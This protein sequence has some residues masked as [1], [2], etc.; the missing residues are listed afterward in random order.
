MSID[1]K[2]P[3]GVFDSGVGGLTVVKEIFRQM[4]IESI[5][6]FGDTLHVPYGSKTPEQ[7]R[8]YAKSISDFLIEQGCKMIIMACN[9]STSLVYEEFKALLTVPVIGMIEP[10]V[11]QALKSTKNN[12]IGVIGTEATIKN[13]AYQ[14]TLMSKKQDVEVIAAP[15][16]YFVPMVE[17]G[18]VSGPE[19]EKTV[20][21]GIKQLLGK[22]IDTLILGCTHYPFL[23]NIIESIVGPGVVVV[24]PAQ[25]TVA[26]AYDKL[27]ELDLLAKEGSPKYDFMVSKDPESFKKIGCV[28]L[29]RDLGMVKE[30]RLDFDE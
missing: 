6:Y 2:A 12:C 19:A 10:G 17:R 13:G 9:T 3:L 16:P 27:R 29:G 25:A 24:D 28:F 5:M 18:V 15:C 22:N 8:K 4:E 14:K 26:A 21:E 23:R 1:R 30:A 11:E 7:I 20:Y